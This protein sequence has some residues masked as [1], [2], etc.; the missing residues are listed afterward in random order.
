LL[1]R[2]KEEVDIV[3]QSVRRAVISGADGSVTD[4][5]GWRPGLVHQHR[6]VCC[7]FFGALGNVIS[8]DAPGSPPKARIASSSFFP[9]ITEKV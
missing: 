4:A 2:A 5:D 3:G 1:W 9:A 7:L 6:E 8:R